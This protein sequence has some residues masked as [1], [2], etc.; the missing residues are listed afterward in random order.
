MTDTPDRLTT[1][2]LD[3]DA[4]RRLAGAVESSFRVRRF[5][6]RAVMVVGAAALI[7]AFWA[8]KHTVDQREMIEKEVRSSAEGATAELA[9]SVEQLTRRIQELERRAHDREL[10]VSLEE[11][12]AP[13]HNQVREVGDAVQRMGATLVRVTARVD[14]LGGELG[15]IEGSVGDVRASVS[16]ERTVRE[17]DVGELDSRLN[18]TATALGGGLA[19]VSSRSERVEREVGEVVFRS[20]TLRAR[21]ATLLPALGLVFVATPDQAG[22]GVRLTVTTPT[23]TPTWSAD[24]AVPRPD[25]T[26]LDFHHEAK[27]HRVSVSTVKRRALWYDTVDVVVRTGPV[28]E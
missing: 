22:P 16:D 6:L 25:A 2:Q 17:R 8:T 19:A 20:V 5:F 10:P 12:L 24:V 28:H 1:V 18:E 23:G 3:R 15:R 27:R 13:L 14:S 26:P 9:A 11:P 21:Q 4:I 7:V